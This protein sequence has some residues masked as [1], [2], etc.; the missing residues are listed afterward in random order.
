MSSGTNPCVL[1]M[2]IGTTSV[3]CCLVDTITKEVI[4]SQKKDTCSNVPSELGTEGNKQD[5]PRILSALQMCV[6]RLP[7][8]SMKRVVRVGVSGQ[9]HGC[10]LWKAGHSWEQKPDSDRFAINEVSNMYTWQDS[11]CTQEFLASLPT[12]QSHLAVSSGYGCATLIWFSKHKPE[13]L[14]RYDRAGTIHD[15]LV[16]MLCGLDQ[17][18]MS[19]HNA[20]SW[21]FFNTV[22]KEWNREVLAGAGLPLNLLPKVVESG[23]TAGYIPNTWYSIPAN[24][25]VLASLGD[26]QCSVLPLLS[27]NTDAVINISTSAQLCFK[28]P[29]EY[30]PAEEPPSTPQPIEYFPFFDGSYLA[31]A[32]SLNGGNALAAFV[33]TIQQWSLDIGFQV[34]QSKIWQRILELGGNPESCSSLIIRPTLFGERNNPEEN[35]SAT[36]VDLGNLSLGKMTRALCKGVITNLHSMMPRSLLEENEITSMIGGGSALV[37]NPILLKELEEAYQMP[38][39]LDTRGDAA[40]GSALAAINTAIA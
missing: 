22:T 23:Q 9:M 38:V 37:R 19:L 31:V 2:D 5:V 35:A 7:R 30:T 28:M 4:S 36:N 6:S 32:A 40:Y 34:P 17:P 11:R 13:L 27:K 12:P 1:G 26:L 20:A 21:G 14:S 16:C 29:P 33:R 8:E 18:V 25:P 39:A 10:M 24:T 15:F 3:K